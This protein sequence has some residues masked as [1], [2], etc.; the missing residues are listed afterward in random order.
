MKKLLTVLTTTLMLNTANAGFFD[1]SDLVKMMREYEKAERSDKTAEYLAVT[2][3]RGFVLGVFDALEYNNLVCAG[4]V[5]KRQVGLIVVKYM[6]ANPELWAR[7]A[8]PLVST[9]LL[10][11]FPCKN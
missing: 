3:F 2:E 11:A 9:A 5:T 1:G 10:S 7:P 4:N 8:F 6:N